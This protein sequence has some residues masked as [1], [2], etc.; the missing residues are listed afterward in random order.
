MPYLTVGIDTE[1][2]NQ[3]SAASRVEPTY[4]NIYALSTLHDR[5]RRCGARPT[6][7][8]TYPVAVDGRASD[9]LAALAAGADCEIGA[10]HHVWETPP[11]DV[12]DARGLPYASQIPLTRFE[13]Q[14]QHL[15]RALHQI[16]GRP[17]VSYRSGRFGFHSSHTAVLERAGYR[18]DTSVQPL[19]YEAHKGG[20]DFVDAPLTPYFLSY[21]SAVSPG[22]STVLEV[23]VSAALNRRLPAWLARAYGRAPQPYQTKRVLRLMGVVKTV[24]LRPS[25]SSCADMKA[26]ARR[27]VESGEPVL[28][29][30]FHSSEAIVGGSPYNRTA[31]ELEAFFDRLS[32]FL[33]YATK[34]LAAEP[35]TFSELHRKWVGRGS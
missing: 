14:L 21:D 31:G 34:D 9:R 13:E 30:I 5:L 7:L 8:A 4:R 1:G 17:P 28:N 19:F 26:L 11:C 16:T 18:V 12:E 15:T 2:D 20:P 23:P 10:H 35:L 27:L 33:D 24:W 22:D 25:F 3:W 6:Y 29:V 32:S